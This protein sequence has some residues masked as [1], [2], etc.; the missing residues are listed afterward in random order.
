MSRPKLKK[1]DWKKSVWKGLRPAL[2]V[3]L[4]AVATSFVGNIDVETVISLGVPAAMA[5]FVVEAGRNWAK[6]RER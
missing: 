4:A 3:G 5:P 6:N 1:Y 2:T